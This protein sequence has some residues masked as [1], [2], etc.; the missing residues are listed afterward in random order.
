[1]RSK[2]GKNNIKL[3]RVAIAWPYPNHRN[4][5]AHNMTKKMLLRS[6]LI[7]MLLVATGSTPVLADGVNPRPAPTC[8][9]TSGPCAPSFS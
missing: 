5:K 8:D 4:L 2:M 6:L 9:P 7:A 3:T 1:M